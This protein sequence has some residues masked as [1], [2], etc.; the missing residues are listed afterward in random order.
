MPPPLIRRLLGL[1]DDAPSDRLLESIRGE[2]NDSEKLVGWIQLGVV[3]VFGTLYFISPK[4]FTAEAEFRPVPWVLSAY[5]L[6]T[7]FRLW[8]SYRRALPGW[9]VTLSIVADIALLLGTIWSFHLQYMQPPS[10]YLKAPTVLYIFIFI[11]LRALRFEGR[12]ILIAGSVAALGWIFM[13]LYVVTVDAEDTMITR[14]YVEY[15]T[16][17]SV[18]IGAEFDKVVSIL[19]VTVI[20][21]VAVTRARTLLISSVREA[22]A[23]KSLSRFFAPEVAQRIAGVEADAGA[24][25][26]S[27]R[28][29]AIMMLDIRGFT[30][31]SATLPPEEIIALLTDYQAQVV[32]I[33]R[34]H[35]GVVDKFLGDGILASFGAVD[36]CDDYAAN[37]LKALDALFEKVDTW[38]SERRRAGLNSV[39][40]NGAATCGPIVFGIIGDAE[41]LE[42]TV[43]GDAVNLAA[44]LEK[45]SKIEDARVVASGACMDLAVAQGYER[46]S[47]WERRDKRSVAGV[48]HPVDLYV[49]PNTTGA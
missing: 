39:V 43:L 16:S 41:R 23:A 1:C 4:T 33:I 35:N 15:L 26:A 2:Q 47:Q 46:K 6:F 12:Y 5:F 44:K 45:Q 37:A 14:N 18:L 32:P 49:K 19:M 9:F 11:A 8:L 7:V 28:D 10:F 36:E 29:A 40:V 21:A 17:N 24:G 25:H 48:D 27:S 30:P 3:L 13:V 42:Y 31:L 34:S 38:N 22:A 20:L